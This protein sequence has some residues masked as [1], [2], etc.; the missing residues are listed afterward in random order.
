VTTI[1]QQARAAIIATLNESSDRPEGI[2][3]ATTRKWNP[4]EELAENEIRIAV[5]F[6]SETP[7]RVG[8]ERG[9]ITRRFH[10]M[11]VQVVTATDKPDEIDDALE[12]ARAW[13]VKRLGKT[14][15]GGLVHS[16][17]EG[18]TRWETAKLER[19]HGA[20]VML[21]EIDYSTNR[22]DLTQRS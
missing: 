8:G 21:W 9:P 15:L 14:N 7:N 20:I 19:M 22:S 11:A 18:Q 16:L 10:A 6:H 3:N 1:L 12:P 5:F 17:K 13:L 4:D 2:P